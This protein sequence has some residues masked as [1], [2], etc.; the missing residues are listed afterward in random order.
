MPYGGEY[1]CKLP[2]DQLVKKS[3]A[4]CNRRFITAFTRVHQAALS[5]LCGINRVCVC[6]E[7]KHVCLV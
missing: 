4:L 5:H 1:F 2:V 6:Y 7:T 3:V